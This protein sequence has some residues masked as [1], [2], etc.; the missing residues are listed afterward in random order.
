M[1]SVSCLGRAGGSAMEDRARGLARHFAPDLTADYEFRHGPGL[2][3]ALA[4][5]PAP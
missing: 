2:G 4:R 3:A 5:H 1:P